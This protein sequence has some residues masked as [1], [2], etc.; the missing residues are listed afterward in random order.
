MYRGVPLMLVSTIVLH[1]MARAK[2]DGWWRGACVCVCVCVWR[3]LRKRMR[4]C[5][6]GV[7]AMRK[8][9]RRVHAGC[10]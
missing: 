2:P 5:V 8:R 7:I 3:G 9:Q 1:D 10:V 6:R 4:M